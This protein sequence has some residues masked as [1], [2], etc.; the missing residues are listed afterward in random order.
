MSTQPQLDE[1]PN[2]EAPELDAGGETELPE[3]EWEFDHNGNYS[4]DDLEI[5]RAMGHETE[6]AAVAPTPAKQPKAKV[7][8]IPL[9]AVTVPDNIKPIKGKSVEEVLAAIPEDQRAEVL[10]IIKGFQSSATKANQAKAKL[11]MPAAK[12]VPKEFDALDPN[13]MSA[14]IEARINEGIRSALSPIAQAQEEEADLAEF[15]SFVEANPLM[16]DDA[17][18]EEVIAMME[19]HPNLDMQDAYIRVENAR[20]KAEKAAQAE[21]YRKQQARKAAA[22]VGAGTRAPA[23]TSGDTDEDGMPIGIDPRDV[24]G[25]VMRRT[26]RA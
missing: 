24:L 12:E 18:V 23:S 1:T 19:K 21:T 2:G 8:P 4:A 13:S 26:T 7:E 20:L 22:R 14:Y 5:F 25:H 17:V 9:D 11:A 16:R 6:V 10:S 15:E 3:H